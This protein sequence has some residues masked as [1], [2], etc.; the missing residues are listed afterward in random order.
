MTVEKVIINIVFIYDHYVQAGLQYMGL[1]V[2]HNLRKRKF[3]TSHID[4]SKTNNKV[5]NEAKWVLL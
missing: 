2:W 3:W 1:F 5:L 4:E